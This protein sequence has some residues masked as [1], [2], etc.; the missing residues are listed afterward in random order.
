MGIT[1]HDDQ[2]KIIRALTGFI[3]KE[4]RAMSSA[5]AFCSENAPAKGS[6]SKK[7]LELK[8]VWSPMDDPRGNLP[9]PKAP[10]GDAS[11]SA[12]CNS[13]VSPPPPPTATTTAAA[14]D[15]VA[16]RRNSFVESN[17]SEASGQRRSSFSVRDG[18]YDVR[19]VPSQL[20]HASANARPEGGRRARSNSFAN[21]HTKKFTARA[22]MSIQRSL[23]SCHIAQ[24]E[25]NSAQ[26]KA[27]LDK[28]RASSIDTEKPLRSD[29]HQ[30]P[31][32][33]LLP[34]RYATA[35]SSAANGRVN[36][37]LPGEEENGDD[38][39]RNARRWTFDGSTADEVARKMELRERAREYGNAVQAKGNV[40]HR[41]TLLSRS[42]LQ[43]F[44]EVMNCEKSSVIFHNQFRREMTLFTE[45]GGCVVFSNT[46][47]IAGECA[48]TGRILN[49][50]D[51]YDFPAFNPNVDKLTGWRT[52][53]VLCEPVYC[54]ETQGVIAVVEMMNKKGSHGE[55]SHFTEQDSKYLG[56][57]CV[58]ISKL[59]H[60]HM[61]ALVESQSIVSKVVAKAD[62]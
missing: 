16:P 33:N 49:I 13:L 35:T 39:E 41:L 44:Q 58:K 40:E 59:L 21:L 3:E 5:G 12:A 22:E 18:D 19:A 46:K 25:M 6:P 11:S 54:L 27:R 42:I 55:H 7:P 34:S 52:R 56:A 20:V 1:L 14:A 8:M 30:Q 47:G 29:A 51:A 32:T 48:R 4:A 17:K 26:R 37:K 10:L 24:N 23:A 45:D 50:P 28:I 36:F 61:A 31:P 9:T 53:S 57:C 43:P 62:R 60:A 2:V 15:A 38:S